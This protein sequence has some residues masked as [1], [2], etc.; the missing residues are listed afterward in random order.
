VQSYCFRPDSRALI[1]YTGFPH[2]VLPPSYCTTPERDRLIREFQSNDTTIPSVFVVVTAIAGGVG[3]NLTAASHVYMME[4]SVNP[5][6]EIQMAGRIHR[7]GQDRP[8]TITKFVYCNHFE[9]NIYALHEE[10]ADGVDIMDGSVINDY[11][12]KI[13]L[14][15]IITDDNDEVSTKSKEDYDE[16]EKD[17]EV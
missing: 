10:I 3:I 12:L 2:V 9:F 4:P 14:N 6:D 17:D 5:Q 16:G 8:V 1:H 7:I 11:A 15:G 13:L